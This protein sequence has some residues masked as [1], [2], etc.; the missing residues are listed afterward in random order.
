MKK[1]GYSPHPKN[2]SFVRRLKSNNFP[3]FHVYIDDKKENYEFSLHL[4]QKGVCYERQTA[5]SGDYDSK[6]LDAE[7]ERI[8]NIL[9]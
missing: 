9:Y 6:V 2:E 1:L 8:I 4:D 5:H 3:R 7:K